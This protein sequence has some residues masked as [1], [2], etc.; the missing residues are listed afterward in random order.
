MKMKKFT[1]KELEEYLGKISDENLYSYNV[2][3]IEGRGK[4]LFKSINGDLT[5]VMGLPIIKIKDYLEK[6]Q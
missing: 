1:Q 5:T 6:L 2:Y 3:Q 4:E